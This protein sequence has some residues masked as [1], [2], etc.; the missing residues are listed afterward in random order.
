MN[1]LIDKFPSFVEIGENQ[2]E[3]NTDFRKCLKIMLAF[4][5]MELT[6][7]EKQLIML[8]NLYKEMPP[9]YLAALKQAVWFLNSGKSEPG[10]VEQPRLFSFSKDAEYIYSGI[11][12]THGI[13]IQQVEAMHWWK[14][15]ALLMSLDETC[16]FNKIVALRSKKLKGKLTK[17][18]AIYCDEI[19]DI[20]EL[21]QVM[22]SEDMA[23]LD[24]FYSQLR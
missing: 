11:M 23:T 10:G 2:Y 1:A 4:E 24:D 22:S 5:D 3:V 16:F 15:T 18:E 19:S 8:G 14:F 7:T 9:D 12:Q 21:P 17:E 6:D 20:L 13:D